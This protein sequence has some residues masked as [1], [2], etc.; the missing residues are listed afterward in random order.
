MVLVQAGVVPDIIAPAGGSAGGVQPVEVTDPYKVKSSNLNVP[1][2]DAAD[3]VSTTVIVPVK[4]VIAL[5]T[6]VEP[7]AAPV[8]GTVPDPTAVPLIVIDQFWAPV[9]LLTLQKSNCVTDI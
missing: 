7:K 5:E 1:D 6:D 2:P 4:F 3:I 8:V 9:A